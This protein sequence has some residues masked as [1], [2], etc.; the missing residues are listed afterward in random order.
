MSEKWK[1]GRESGERVRREE[2]EREKPVDGLFLL[3]RVSHLIYF[4]QV[5][6]GT[7]LPQTLFPYKHYLY[8]VKLFL[9][10]CQHV[11]NV[12]GRQLLETPEE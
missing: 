2:E 11:G 6:C 7:P 4:G 8:I 5:G 9:D 3:G 12:L 10:H 1:E